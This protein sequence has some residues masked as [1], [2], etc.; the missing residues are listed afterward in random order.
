MSLRSPTG[1]LARWALQ[2]QAY[3]IT[4]KYTPG[5]TNVVADT[6][7]RPI[8]DEALTKEYGICSVE[9]EMPKRSPSEI[10]K[11]QLK[12]N[13]VHR[14]VKALEDTERNEN[15]VYWS[16][17]GYLMNNGLL[18][19]YN[20]TDDSEDAQLVVPQQEWANVLSAYHDDPLAGHYGADKT[21]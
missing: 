15:A 4:I 12:D 3:D 21:Y 11:E 13:Y 18:Y 9:V 1:R 17:K 6:L 2:I 5:R 19:R 14:I 16:N 8:C 7:S 10:R 20:P